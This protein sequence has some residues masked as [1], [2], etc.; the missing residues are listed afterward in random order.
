MRNAGFT[1][2]E[3]VVVISVIALI[4]GLSIAT[5]NNFNLE[6]K[7]TT[8][9][10]KLVDIIDLA[11]KRALSADLAQHT[12]D[13]FNG[14]SVAVAANAVTTSICCNGSCTVVSSYSFQQ[15]ID[16]ATT[17]SF[18]FNSLTA[19]TTASSIKLR[20]VN[21]GKCIPISITT[22]GII[23]E[24]AKCTCTDPACN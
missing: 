16:A 5:Y 10:K 8:D 13:S 1:L 14:Y 17:A 3:L 20:S 4:T 24:S 11:R 7:L 21:L 15:G 19:N 22:N 6:Q 2:I 12:C 23:T 9:A 18:T